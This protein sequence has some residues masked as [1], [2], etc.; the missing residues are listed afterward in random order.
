MG[1]RLTQCLSKRCLHTCLDIPDPNAYEDSFTFTI[2]HNGYTSP[3]ATVYIHVIPTNVSIVTETADEAKMNP[4][5]S[6][7]TIGVGELVYCKIMG[8]NPFTQPQDV[9]WSLDGEG[10]DSHSLIVPDAPGANIAGFYAGDRAADVTLTAT[11]DGGTKS[12]SVTFTLVEPDNE[13]AR[14]VAAEEV[15]DPGLGIYSWGVRMFIE[16][17][18]QPQ[19]VCFTNVAVKEV[20]GPA[21]NITG[22][23]QLVPIGSL[24]HIGEAIGPGGAAPWLHF[25]KDNV[26]KRFDRV[27]VSGDLLPVASGSW[28]WDIPIVWRTSKSE[29]ERSTLENRVQI[30]EVLDGNTGSVRVTKFG[31]SKP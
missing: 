25:D 17:T 11:F 29:V 4:D 1:G 12:A 15:D 28:T 16:I 8:G 26:G 6:R 2:T 18:L 19:T 22:G 13:T 27:E 24:D 5:F 20:P 10:I 7:K 31:L 23:Y 9:V 3:P 21:S 14:K 30:N